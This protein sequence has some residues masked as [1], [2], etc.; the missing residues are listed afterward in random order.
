MYAPLDRLVDES[1]Y[2]DQIV[3]TALVSLPSLEYESH[4]Q[5]SPRSL[6]LVCCLQWSLLTISASP[7]LLCY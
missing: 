7:H 5:H 3:H 1:P 4:A 6:P 2:T